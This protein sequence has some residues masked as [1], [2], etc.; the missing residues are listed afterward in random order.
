MMISFF[1]FLF[2][3]AAKTV[4]FEPQECLFC[5]EQPATIMFQPCQHVIAC[6]GCCIKTKRCPQ[7]HMP[8]TA[9]ISPGRKKWM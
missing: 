5:S 9:K 2:Y 1:C 3:S 8:I 7:C 4:D 6:P